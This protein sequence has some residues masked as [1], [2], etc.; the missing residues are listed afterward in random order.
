[1]ITP[2]Q[3]ATLLTT[4]EVTPSL[5]LIFLRASQGRPMSDISIADIWSGVA[6]LKAAIST[7][8]LTHRRPARSPVPVQR[9]PA[10]T[11]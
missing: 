3:T 9:L 11:T 10:T 6:V 8:E 1:M 2:E 5:P 7:F 4:T